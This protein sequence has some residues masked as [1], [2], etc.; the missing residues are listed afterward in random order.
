[1]PAPASAH[2]SGGNGDDERDGGKQS[3]THD[4]SPRKTEILSLSR[5]SGSS[6]FRT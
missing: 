6:R 3:V 2:D 4:R 1:M 5:R